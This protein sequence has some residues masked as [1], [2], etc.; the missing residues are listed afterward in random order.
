M[1]LCTQM[2]E[3]LYTYMERPEGCVRR[4]LPSL[5]TLLPLG[6]L[7]MNCKCAVLA[8]IADQW[9]SW[10]CLHIQ[11]LGLQADVIIPGSLLGA[12]DWQWHPHKCTPKAHIHQ[13]IS[14]LIIN[15]FED[16]MMLLKYY[17]TFVHIKIINPL[18]C[19]LSFLMKI[20]AHSH[21]QILLF[22][23]KE[24]KTRLWIGFLSFPSNFSAKCKWDME[25]T[26]WK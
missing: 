26:K 9:A 2:C 1:C 15:N 25:E 22:S 14:V 3:C 24:N 18:A 16:G 10:L 8:W 12:C 19:Y 4:C 5:S 11:M 7:S 20:K 13:A 23:E 17:L 21:E 6:S